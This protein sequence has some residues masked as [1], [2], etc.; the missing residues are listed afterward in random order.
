MTHLERLA[1]TRRAGSPCPVTLLG[2]EALGH[3]ARRALDRLGL[4]N[5]LTV[6]P[7]DPAVPV[8][9][10]PCLIVL[11]LHESPIRGLAVLRDLR[12][13]KP[14]TSIPVLVLGPDGEPH[15]LEQAYAFGA[16]SYL[17]RPTTD[18]ELVDRLG[19]A[20]DY[21]LRISRTPD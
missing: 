19:L 11:E 18:A 21:W 15:V 16:S 2:G 7:V 20:L 14:L 4:P 6:A 3:A 10:R 12:A 8:A 1:G 17:I 9:G 5:P 13:R